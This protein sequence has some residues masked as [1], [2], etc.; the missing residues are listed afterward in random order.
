MK[1]ICISKATI[2]VE[3]KRITKQT[4]MG[5]VFAT[6]VLFE[7]CKVKHLFLVFLYLT[8]FKN[9]MNFSK[10][11]RIHWNSFHDLFHRH[12]LKK[13]FCWVDQQ[14]LKLPNTTTFHLSTS[15][16]F[17]LSN[18]LVND[19]T[20][21]E[22]KKSEEDTQIYQRR[23]SCVDAINYNGKLPS[24][25]LTQIRGISISTI[26]RCMFLSVW[27]CMNAGGKNCY[28]LRL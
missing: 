28:K 27:K 23:I 4:Q 5:N 6:N 16:D 17:T 25:Y 13:C 12:H 8:P 3:F 2:W 14:M 7:S 22:P 20:N 18:A 24:F 10:I 1:C 21:L 15:P 19:L 26:L 11:K 9:R